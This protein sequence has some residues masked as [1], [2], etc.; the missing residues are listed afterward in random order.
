MVKLSCQI[1]LP[2][3]LA[4]TPKAGPVGLPEVAV[5]IDCVLDGGKQPGGPARGRRGVPGGRGCAQRRRLP[6]P[7]SGAVGR[8]RTDGRR[9]VHRV[10]QL[11]G[12]QERRSCASMASAGVC[13]EGGRRDRVLRVRMKPVAGPGGRMA[14]RLAGARRA[15]RCP[16]T[17]PGTVPSSSAPC[18]GPARRPCLG[19]VSRPCPP[20]PKASP[21][22]ART[23]QLGR[24]AVRGSAKSR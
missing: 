16:R 20:A 18:S 24:G 5:H 14:V 9:G 6:H 13:G 19:L 7:G 4:L 1:R 22:Q 8:L 21:I 23:R 10:H 15:G 11:G 17:I 3:V 12:F 2:V